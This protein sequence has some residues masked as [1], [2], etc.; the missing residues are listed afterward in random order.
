[1]KMKLKKISALI[2]AAVIL[3]TTNGCEQANA[4]ETGNLVQQTEISNITSSDGV[5][6]FS[7][8]GGLYEKSFNL[9]L[10]SSNG[11]KIRYTLDGTDPTAQSTAYLSPITIYDR[12]NEENN[13][14]A[15]ITENK[16]SG[17]GRNERQAEG[18][19]KP[20]N[21]GA[22]NKEVQQGNK[23]FNK[24]RDENQPEDPALT[25]N[26]P[27][28]R[29]EGN[30]ERGGGGFGGGAASAP[31]EKVF[32]GT[33]VK[34]AVFSESGEQI[35]Q[36]MVQS[37][38]VNSDIFA[39]YNLPVVS[40]VTDK[41]N[42][43]DDETGIYANSGE[44]GAEWE[45]PVHFELYAADGTLGVSQNMG[46]RISGNS[47]RTYQ[48][49]SMRFYAKAEYDAVNTSVEYEIFDDLTKSYN[50]EALSTFKRV[51]LRNSGNDNSSTMLRDSL[52]QDLVSDLNVDTQ[53]SQPCVAFVNGEFWGIYNIRERY[54]DQYFAAHYDI[55]KSNVAL[56]EITNSGT[57]PEVNE[58]DESDLAYYQEMWNFF[59]ENSMAEAENYKK[60]SEY[61][62]IDNFIDYYIANIYSGNTD[63]PG[64]NNVFWRYKTEN[65]GYDSTASWYMDGR[66]RWVLK[67]MDFGFGLMGQVSSDTLTHAM[68]EEEG[69]NFGRAERN[70]EGVAQ[71]MPDGERMTAPPKG[72]NPQQ[73]GENANFPDMKNGQE[74]RAMGFTNASS[75]LIFRRLLENT[76]F[77]NKFINRFCDVM[78]TNYETNYVLG[79]IE[80][81][82]GAIETAMPEQVN[83]YQSA[84]GS[85]EIWAQNI[86]KMSS[87]VKERA[88]Y[89]QGFLKEK[90]SLNDVVTVNLVTD[91]EKGY[92]KINDR[93]ITAETKG[94]SN[95][96]SWRGSYFA[97]TS[98]ILT[99]VPNEGLIFSHFSVTDLETGNIAEYRDSTI[100]LVL[101]NKGTTVQ[102]VFK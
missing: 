38:F 24:A 18:D 61:I 42:F 27:F 72:F 7:H 39:K 89:V 33:V 70:E 79:Q 64:N 51:L 94:V 41:A 76:Q 15:I 19:N 100:N 60:A 75:T 50:D 35:S 73:N 36:T 47:T 8:S 54:D 6:V 12:T 93:E 78:N 10:S 21:Q 59:N 102:A 34:A 2:L 81:Y 3:T 57:T 84:I 69:R 17:F 49:K 74:G 14:S 95:P 1:M 13:L 56:L 48:Q 87:F 23:D 40:I 26:M 86:D 65:G 68:S 20:P 85:M 66:Y 77:K 4:N 71:K 101:G 97:G 99:A 28:Q 46:V 22:E 82:K 53:A 16:S 44:S 55:K 30:M 92:I 52:M 98:Q 25:E 91:S 62:D 63:W 43:Y 31:A 96:S 32:K 67:D 9:E 58:G 37:Y 11:G 80:E 90:F 83:R 5:L 45:R 29:P 88:A